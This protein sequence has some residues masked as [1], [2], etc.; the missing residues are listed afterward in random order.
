MGNADF[1][2]HRTQLNPRF[3]LCCKICSEEIGVQLRYFLNK[4]SIACPSCG[5]VVDDKA[6]T[7]LRQ[8]IVHLDAAIKRLNDVS[9][10]YEDILKQKASSFSLRIDWDKYS[11][12][13]DYGLFK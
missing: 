1:D 5:Q 12:V 8:S 7:D 13:T 2:I 9:V 11:M 6:F 10:N 3:V 4:T